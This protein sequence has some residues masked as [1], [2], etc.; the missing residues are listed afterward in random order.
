MSGNLFDG[1]AGGGVLL[2]FST[3]GQSAA[4]HPT[5]MAPQQ[6]I[7][8]PQVSVEDKKL[9]FRG[10]QLWLELSV[11][12]AWVDSELHVIYLDI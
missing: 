2:A 6:R 10:L 9:A 5:A 3:R 7:A 11:Q 1:L 8:Q 12:V 4:T